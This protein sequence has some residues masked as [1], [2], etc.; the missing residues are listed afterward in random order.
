ML[1]ANASAEIIFSAQDFA[2]T[3]SVIANGVLSKEVVS[4][5]NSNQ[6]RRNCS[7]CR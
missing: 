6:V 2:P 1:A 5:R 7:R 4:S 3:R